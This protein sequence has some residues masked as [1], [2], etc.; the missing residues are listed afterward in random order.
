MCQ[1]LSGNEHILPC[2]RFPV[3]IPGWS[4]KDAEGGSGW[5]VEQIEAGW[6]TEEEGGGLKKMVED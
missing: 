3:R 2:G 5:A 1:Q 6:R 4:L